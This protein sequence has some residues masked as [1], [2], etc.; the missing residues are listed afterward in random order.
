MGLEGFKK[1]SSLIPTYLLRVVGNSL[2]EWVLEQ[3]LGCGTLLKVFDQTLR[4]E[5][6]EF[7]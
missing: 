3:L 7:H 2:D 1:Y 6:I 4:D 5:I